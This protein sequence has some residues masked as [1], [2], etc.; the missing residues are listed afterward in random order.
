MLCASPYRYDHERDGCRRLRLVKIGAGIINTLINKL[1]FELH[2]PGDYQFCGPGTNVEKHVAAGHDIKQ[3][4][5]WSKELGNEL[6][7]GTQV[8]KK[9]QQLG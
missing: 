2:I 5:S 1:P 6:N 3:I 9:K 7:R 8:L 4:T